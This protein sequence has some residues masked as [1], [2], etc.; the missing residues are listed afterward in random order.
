MNM[1]GCLVGMALRPTYFLTACE[2][3]DG[4]LARFH[5][6]RFTPELITVRSSSCRSSS[7]KRTAAIIC[8]TDR[9]HLRALRFIVPVRIQFS[10][11]P[12]RWNK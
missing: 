3:I 12:R 7:Q 11:I 9:E 5:P 2:V 10:Q 6:A 8:P 1:L 4:D